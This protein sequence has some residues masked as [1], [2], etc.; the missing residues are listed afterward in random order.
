LSYQIVDS[1][2]HLSKKTE[3]LVELGCSYEI[4]ATVFSVSFSEACA[5]F[6]RTMADYMLSGH[7]IKHDETVAY[8]YWLTKGKILDDRHLNFF[9]YNPEATEFI[10]G[11]ENTLRYWCSQTTL[12]S[13]E[14]AKFEAPRP[15]QMVA[16]SDGVYEGDAVEGVRY[17]SP[18]HMSG[19]WLTTNRFDGDIKSLKVVHLFHLTENRPDLAKY[20]AL[21]YGYRFSSQEDEV[22]F[23]GKAV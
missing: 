15:D 9:E 7:E 12:C 21:P 19:W 16:I 13:R 10:F 5:D 20:L 14:G 23:D 8:G 2:D 18:P 1:I 17:G 22:W 6:V 3:G 4:S 11:I